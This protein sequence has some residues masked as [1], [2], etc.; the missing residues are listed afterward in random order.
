MGGL[1]EALLFAIKAEK[2]RVGQAKTGDRGIRWSES[3]DHT[4]QGHWSRKRAERESTNPQSVNPMF[5][6]FGR[7][8]L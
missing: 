6:Y 2:G 8:Y 7:F 3:Q 1:G 4:N 5:C